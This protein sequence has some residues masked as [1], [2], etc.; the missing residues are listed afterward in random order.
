MAGM[1]PARVLRIVGM[2]I[3]FSLFL[4]V[5]AGGHWYIARGFVLDPQWGSTATFWG[6]AGIIFGFVL[7]IAAPIA[8][9]NLSRDR[10]RWLAWPASLWMGFAFLG[11]VFLGISDVLLAIVLGVGAVVGER[12]GFEAQASLDRAQAV[13]AGLVTL[14]VGF[15]AVREG[16]S[17]PRVRQVE[18]HL[19]RWPRERDGLRIVQ[20]SDIHIGAL[21]GRSFASRLVDAVNALEAD[22]VAVTGDLV[23]GRVQHLAAEVEPFSRLRG[24]EGVFFVTGNHDHYSGAD[25]WAACVGELGLSVLRNDH[26]IL[27]RGAGAI[28][29]V[30]VDD[31]RGSFG[32]EEGGE[33][34]DRALKGLAPGVPVVLLAHDPGSFKAACARGVDLQISGHTHDGQIWPFRY[35]VRL[36]TPFVEG[37]H[38]RG[39]SQIYVSRGTGFW[40]PPMRLGAPAEITEIVL[41]SNAALD[42]RKRERRA[43]PS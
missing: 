39:D 34:L 24:R 35:A 10:S 16:L 23:D 20:I 6:L 33:D 4:A 11:L 26:R 18:I 22:I 17:F 14:I 32:G 29:I 8:E 7:L 1:P 41:R 40:G 30:G 31:H 37:V 13:A 27:G 19:S 43:C 5:V 15:H 42:E 9:R 38:V 36:A 21:L 28:A 12:A 2:L 25:E 3:V